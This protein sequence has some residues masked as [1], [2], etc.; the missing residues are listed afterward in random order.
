MS[1]QAPSATT[2]KFKATDREA[3][4]DMVS[5]RRHVRFRVIWLSATSVGRRAFTKRIV[6]MRPRFVIIVIR[7][8]ILRIIVLDWREEWGRL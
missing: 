8:T 3:M 6:T 7:L 2:K 5:A 4:I 1:T